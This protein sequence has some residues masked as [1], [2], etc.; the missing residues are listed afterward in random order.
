[1]YTLRPLG[2]EPALTHDNT[3]TRDCKLA[4]EIISSAEL[5][6][7]SWISDASNSACDNSSYARLS[8]ARMLLLNENEPAVSHSSFFPSNSWTFMKRTSIF[9]RSRP[10]GLKLA[11]PSLENRETQDSKINDKSLH[12]L[13]D[14][15][16]SVFAG[17]LEPKC[18]HTDQSNIKKIWGLTVTSARHLPSLSR[19]SVRHCLRSSPV[20]FGSRKQRTHL[21]LNI[22]TMMVQKKRRYL[23]SPTQ[24]TAGNLCPFRFDLKTKSSAINCGYYGLN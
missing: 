14:H 7:V 2:E 6:P 16:G 1:M 4:P 9:F 10:G 23:Q 15:D 13:R 3:G 22:G 19:L 5:R 11:R 18:A 24:Y 17:Q 8:W 20:G 21:T 12:Q